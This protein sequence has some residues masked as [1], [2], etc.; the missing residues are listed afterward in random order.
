MKLPEFATALTRAESKLIETI[1]GLTRGYCV[2]GVI[3][4][5]PT[6]HGRFAV[7]IISPNPVDASFWSAHTFP[8]MAW[9]ASLSGA[10]RSREEAQTFVMLIVSGLPLKPAPLEPGQPVAG[11]IIQLRI[12]NVNEITPQTYGED[13]EPKPWAWVS[14]INLDVVFL[15]GSRDISDE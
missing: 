8:A 11:E 9:R 15:T 14:T 4:A 1:A 7:R 3:G 6:H 12:A 2:S 13:N 5:T 10:F